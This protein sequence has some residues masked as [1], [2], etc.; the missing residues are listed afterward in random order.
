MNS[1]AISRDI[2][3]HDHEIVVVNK[4]GGLL[5][6]PGRGPDRQDCLSARL[7][8]C[9]PEMIDQPAVH[10]LD[11]YTTGLMVF[12]IDRKTHRQLSRQFAERR[13]Y[14]EYTGLLE[15][16]VAAEHGEIHLR[17]RLDPTNR[18]HQIHDPV[19]GKM[20]STLWR[21]LAHENGRTRVRFIPLTGRTHQLRL[22]AAHPLGLACP[23][24]GDHLYGSGKDGDPMLLHA[25][26]LAFT[27]PASG[28][29]LD[30]TLPAPF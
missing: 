5:S 17:F 13:V 3:Y 18:P 28:L 21:R 22:H 14:K 1:S 12:A 15:G 9:F 8:R 24:V 19:N 7:R 2:C 29:S 25:S 16:T 6:V 30:F 10:R 23:I 27:H 26:R 4:P 20:G 11:M